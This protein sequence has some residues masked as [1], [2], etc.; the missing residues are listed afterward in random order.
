M[1]IPTLLLLAS[2][3]FAEPATMTCC[4]S[5]TADK[6]ARYYLKV[7]DSFL[8]GDVMWTAQIT[9]W[10]SYLAKPSAAL[11][12]EAKEAAEA[13]RRELIRLQRTHDRDTVAGDFSE[14]GRLVGFLV[15]RDPGGK[16]AL[17]EAACGEVY[18]LQ[19][20]D[21]PLRHWLDLPCEPRWVNER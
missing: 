6:S 5:R 7:R 21:E 9:G 12:P 10:L 19:P 18:W 15:L 16:R 8:A 20:P 2:P 4:A 17:A 1:W 11:D 13:L 14:V 3:T